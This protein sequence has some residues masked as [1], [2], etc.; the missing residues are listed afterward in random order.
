[1][2]IGPYVLDNNVI[3]APMAGV[4]DVPF[5][6]LCMRM[7]AGLA[8]SEMLSSNPQVWATEKSRERMLHHQDMGV[9]AVQIAGSDPDLMAQAA[10]HNVRQG[11]QIIDINMGCPAKKVNK[12]LAGSALLQDPK[13]VTDILH[14]VVAAVNVPVTL[15]IRTG[16][17]RE[18]RN[19]V[20]IAQIAEQAG[21]QSLAVHGRTREDMY[22]GNAE[23][24]T[25]RAIKDA[26]SIP[27]VA[28]GDI[29]TPQQAKFV[30]DYT[31]ADAV[32]VGRGAQG[33]PWLFREIVHYLATGEEMKAP[34]IDEIT[35]IMRTHLQQL[36]TFYG[37]LKG[38]RIARK[39]IGWY[40]QAI[41]DPLGFRSYFNTLESAAEQADALNNYFV[42]LQERK[43]RYYV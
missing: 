37:D 13:L 35:A 4:T 43:E 24:D 41:N 19:G 40:L 6:N 10:Q 8:V 30:L 25:I 11:A 17:A 36:H 23:Y 3:L 21:I 22:K 16:W 34:G 2:R 31:N 42:N 14:A 20:E 38:L 27:V 5:R 26:V 18:K 15:K 28:N 32:M 29:T 1:M 9:R 12:K 39:H 7:G 33:R